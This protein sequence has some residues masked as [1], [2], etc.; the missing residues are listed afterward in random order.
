LL[1]EFATQSDAAD[2][3]VSF[4]AD[5]AHLSANWSGRGALSFGVG[6]ESLGGGVNPGGAFRT[7]LAT[8]H[9]FNG[10]ADKF[11]A[12][13]DAGLDDRYATVKIAAGKWNLTGVLHDFSAEA[14]NGDFGSELDLSAAR[15]LGNHYALLLKAAFFS[16][17]SDSSLTDTDKF[18]LLLTASY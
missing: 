4:D 8:L 13:P 7:P 15:K 12:T 14:G 5:Y 11:L 9:A 2:A 6:F 17:D 18:W 10:W 16:A 3:P 1:G